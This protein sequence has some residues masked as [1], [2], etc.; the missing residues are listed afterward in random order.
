MLPDSM[1]C[2]TVDPPPAELKGAAGG[3]HDGYVV[4]CGGAIDEK[5]RKE[6]KRLAIDSHTWEKDVQLEEP[7]AFAAHTLVP[8]WGMWILGGMPV[9]SMV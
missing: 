1:D 5:P 7:R 3:L 8:K 2:D 9:T 4:V 6:C